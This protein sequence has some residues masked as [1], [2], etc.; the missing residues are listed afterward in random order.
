M[1][2]DHKNYNLKPCTSAP[3]IV[4]VNNENTKV[5]PKFLTPSKVSINAQGCTSPKETP[6]SRSWVQTNRDRPASQQ[7]GFL[8]N[9]FHILTDLEDNSSQFRYTEKRGLM[10]KCS[11]IRNPMSF[12]LNTMHMLAPFKAI[13]TIT[14]NDFNM[15]IRLQIL[16]RKSYPRIQVNRGTL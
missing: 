4:T 12:H 14:A 13:S 1:Y 8:T 9:R 2:S 10:V 7:N 6:R 5:K 15:R 16:I 3:R 11:L